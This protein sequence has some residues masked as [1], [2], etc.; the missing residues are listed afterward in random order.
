M[1]FFFPVVIGLLLVF[2]VLTP[3]FLGRGGLL[4]ASSSINSKEKL[5]F[6]KGAILNQY[7]ADET[8]FLANEMSKL[9]WNARKTFLINRYID[10]SRRLDYLQFVESENEAGV[11]S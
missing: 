6:L 2:A 4:A 8:I 1:E 10:S 9:A 11:Q 7:L 5:E 3:F